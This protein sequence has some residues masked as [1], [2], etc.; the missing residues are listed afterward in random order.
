MN[1]KY[2]KVRNEKLYAIGYDETNHRYLLVVVVPEIVWYNRYYLI[3]KVE[4]D[5]FESKIENLDLL[6][7][8]C[9]ET[10]IYNNRFL[11]SDKSSEN[12][13]GKKYRLDR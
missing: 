10:G 2:E 8:E 9:Y 3:S 4:Y 13:L 12:E 6:A 5:W 7:K 11:F 1:L